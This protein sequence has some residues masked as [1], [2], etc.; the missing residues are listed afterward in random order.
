M[1]V[2]LCGGD[3][4]SLTND[5]WS[6]N[7]TDHPAGE[8]ET[9]ALPPR[10]LFRTSALFYRKGCPGK[11]LRGE[12]QRTESGKADDL[13]DW[14]TREAW[15]GEAPPCRIPPASRRLVIP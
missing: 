10:P 14:A 6:V 8:S 15:Q 4:K 11:G 5:P 7:E 3:R 13:H 12:F 1:P 2:V 9:T